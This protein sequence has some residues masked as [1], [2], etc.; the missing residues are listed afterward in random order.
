MFSSAAENRA[1]LAILLCCVI[2]MIAVLIDLPMLFG[3]GTVC[4]IMAVIVMGAAKRSS[5]GPLRVP[6]AGLLVLL[7]TS[8]TAVIAMPADTDP[9]R[10]I[11]GLPPRVALTLFGVWLAPLP[12]AL[13]S[14]LLTFDSFTL[15]EGDLEQ[16]RNCRNRTSSHS[17]CCR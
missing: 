13:L 1:I 16:L 17:L 15:T 9:S 14:Y 8:I 2:L 5:L 7:L 10:L 11:L 6:L 3:A 12:V 4:F